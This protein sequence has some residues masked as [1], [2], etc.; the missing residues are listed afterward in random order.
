MRKVVEMQTEFWKRNIS[1][2]DLLIRYF[3]DNIANL[4]YSGKKAKTLQKAQ[5]AAGRLNH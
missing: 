5:K 2:S 1:E 3:Q 4:L